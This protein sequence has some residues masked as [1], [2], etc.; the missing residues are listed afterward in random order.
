[1][2]VGSREDAPFAIYAKFD[3][4][5]N[6]PRGRGGGYNGASGELELASGKPLSSKGTQ[7]VPAGDRLIVRMPGGGG[8]GDPAARDPQD[9][10]DDVLDGYVSI[11]SARDVYR[12]VIGPDSVVDE[13]A[14]RILRA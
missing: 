8:L 14:T 1:M 7:I 2:E 5:E 3:R 4:V 9:V 13:Q 12:V 11:E 6:P 10:L